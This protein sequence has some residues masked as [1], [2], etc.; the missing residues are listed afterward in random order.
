MALDF[1]ISASERGRGAANVKWNLQSDVNG[2]V[3]LRELLEYVRVAQI[4]VTQDVLEDELRRGFPED[5][6]TITDGRKGKPFRLVK[7]LGRID[8]LA[9]ETVS[10]FVKLMFQEVI[11]LSKV[12]TGQYIKSHVLLYNGKGV[13]TTLTEAVAWAEKADLK[14]GDVI[15]LI[16]T[17]PYARRL[18]L[19]GVT[20]MG[21]NRKTGKSKDK[22]RAN[23]GIIVRK[24]N[25][26][27]RQAYRKIRNRFKGSGKL[28]FKFLPGGQI[29]GLSGGRRNFKPRRKGEDGR[30]Y[31]YPSLVW[32]VDTQGVQ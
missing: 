22:K 27:Y 15:R 28:Q 10:E 30:P 18:E 2:E 4:R 31:L 20:S 24:P 21:Y 16:N 13:A 19:L 26:A 29:G 23:R 14:T 12:V 25:G 5:Y 8:I 9:R 7:P 32:R 11:R 3:T 6:V 1:S 17:A